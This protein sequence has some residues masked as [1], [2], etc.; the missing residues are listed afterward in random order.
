[1]SS[2]GRPLISVIV[3]CHNYGRFLPE[4]LD[5]ALAQTY[6]NLEVLLMD[7]GSTDDSL[8]VASR[9]A[10]SI[11][12]LTQENQGVERAANRAV[13][14]ATGEL[15]AFLSADDVF[16]P[17]YVERL[18]EGLSR[19]DGAS[20]SFCRARMFGA[21]TGLIK[22]FPFSLYLLAKLGN[23]VNGSAL[24]RRA[25]FLEAGGYDPA[26][27]EHGFED[28]DLW[29]RMV[30][31]GKRGTFVSEPL[32]NWR[33]HETA[34]RNLDDVRSSDVIRRRHLALY[35]SI[36]DVRGRLYYLIDLCVAVIDLGLRL[37]RRPRLLNALERSSWRRFERH[38]APKL[39]AG[40]ST[41]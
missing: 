28:W 19:S 5:S 39:G 3:L 4:A 27:A 9:Y 8:E 12:I 7:D 16:E 2:A 6:P 24:T 38:H 18:H 37:S 21:R 26:L 10:D 33:R 11:R 20:F 14:E 29:L 13:G 32:L 1:L 35:E 36:S 34:S 22:G 41:S 30:E 25:D 15:F 40:H 17:T 23:F 31:L